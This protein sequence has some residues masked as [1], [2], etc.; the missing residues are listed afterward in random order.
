MFILQSRLCTLSKWN[1]IITNVTGEWRMSL[2]I[3]IDE[4]TINCK[5]ISSYMKVTNLLLILD[6][7]MHY[8]WYFIF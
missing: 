5:I 6:I 3:T 2:K 7:Y 1:I 4:P 8:A